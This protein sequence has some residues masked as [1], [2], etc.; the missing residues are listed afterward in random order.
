M[1]KEDA[2]NVVYLNNPSKLIAI[3]GLEDYVVVDTPDVLM[4]CPRDDSKIQGFLSEL[5]MPEFEEY[6]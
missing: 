2:N 1:F 6:R 4:I 3:R 5:A